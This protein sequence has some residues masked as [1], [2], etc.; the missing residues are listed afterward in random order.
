MIVVAR[1]GGSGL[2]GVEQ[3]AN[4]SVNRVAAQMA[5]SGV[6]WANGLIKK[7][8]VIDFIKWPDC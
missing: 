3:L 5:K 8:R 6:N 4:K 1:P 7:S 2:V